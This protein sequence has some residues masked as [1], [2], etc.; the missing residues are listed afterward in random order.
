MSD[1]TEK[2][3]QPAKAPTAK[4]EV[5]LLKNHTHAGTDYAPGTVIEI[6]QA[7]ADR[8]KAQGVI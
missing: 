8:L 4:V 1:A 7:Q 6:T 5:K 3:M 2:P